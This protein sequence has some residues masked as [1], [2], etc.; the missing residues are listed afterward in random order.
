MLIYG[1]NDDTAVVFS[2]SASFVNYQE[3]GDTNG[4][5]TRTKSFDICLYCGDDGLL[6]NNK[7]FSKNS[8]SSDLYPVLPS[9]CGENTAKFYVPYKNHTCTEIES[10]PPA[11][12]KF[13]TKRFNFYCENCGKNGKVEYNGACQNECGANSRALFSGRCVKKCPDGTI[14]KFSEVNSSSNSTYS[15][16]A[17]PGNTSVI[18]FATIGMELPT[19]DWIDVVNFPDEWTISMWIKP[20]DKMKSKTTY[21]LAD[22]VGFIQIYVK[23]QTITN[24]KGYASVTIGSN[25]FSPSNILITEA[26]LLNDTKW[27]Y[28]GI[29]KG[30]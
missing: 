29:S 8:S 21:S 26:G 4:C 18:E 12:D 5:Q 17:L 20:K 25:T 10:N 3:A 7:C 27:T 11:Y 2:T 9:K 14:L 23:M 19:P 30:V 6:K 13:C 24:A 28:V 22:I 16:V 1:G 15:P